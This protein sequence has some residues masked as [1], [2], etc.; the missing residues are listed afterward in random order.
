MEPHLRKTLLIVIAVL[1]VTTAVCLGIEYEV[2][3]V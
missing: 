3:D 1:L 2:I